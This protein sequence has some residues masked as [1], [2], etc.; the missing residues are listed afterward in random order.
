VIREIGTINKQIA[1]R[2]RKEYR[3]ETVDK[4]KKKEEKKIS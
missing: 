4:E 3:E 1:G 2:T